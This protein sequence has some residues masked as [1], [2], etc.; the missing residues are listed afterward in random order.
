MSIFCKST[1][2]QPYNIVPILM[3]VK[4]M[5]FDIVHIAQPYVRPSEV[6]KDDCKCKSIVLVKL[7]TSLCA[8]WLLPYTYDRFTQWNLICCNA[9][10]FLDCW[11][12]LHHKSESWDDH[13]RKFC[14]RT[15]YNDKPLAL[16]LEHS[17]SE[18]S[19]KHNIPPGILKIITEMFLPH[20]GLS[21]LEDECFSKILPK[22]NN[23]KNVYWDLFCEH[24][25]KQLLKVQ[26]GCR[27][28]E[29]SLN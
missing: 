10:V 6:D 24:L 18:P 3:L 12:S 4:N 11:H 26:R 14:H 19:Q 9:L 25:H 21:E 23:M 1:N 29:Q 7:G 13:I 28:W 20:I 17:L 16:C 2:Y 15:I 8:L 27:S 22:V 5:I